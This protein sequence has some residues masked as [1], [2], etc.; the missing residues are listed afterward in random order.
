V[1]VA[2][3]L[4]N[5]DG[6]AVATIW[7]GSKNMTDWSGCEVVSLTDGRTHAYAEGLCV[8]DGD[9][10][11]VGYKTTAD[12]TKVAVL[13]KNGAETM[14]SAVESYATSVSVNNGKVYVA[15]WEYVDI[16]GRKC[17]VAT[18][19]EDGVAHHLYDQPHSS[20]ARCVVVKGKD[21]Y[22]SGFIGDQAVVWT[23]GTAGA[24]TDGYKPSCVTSIFLK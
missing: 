12:D 24:L 20:Q 2:G 17:A 18:L 22:V 1:Y 3:E 9:V 4:S 5:A 11:A 14:L 10:Y 13:W 19:W 8:E 7:K 15:G 21:V 16:S 23:N 6:F